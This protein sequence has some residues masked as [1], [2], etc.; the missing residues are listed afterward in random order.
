M[1]R[2]LPDCATVSC[3]D[4]WPSWALSLSAVVSSPR[5]DRDP[6]ILCRFVDSLGYY[7]L[8]LQVGDFGL[9]IYLTQIIFGAV[10]VPARYSSTFMLQK[11][12][13]R[14]SQLGTLVMGGLMCITIIFIPAGTGPGCPLFPP[15]LTHLWPVASLSG[16]RASLGFGYRRGAESGWT[17]QGA[18]PS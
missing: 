14:W 7:G 18:G 12:G 9:D 15:A 10:E 8:S 17:G 3:C 2:C 11:F 13:R 6:W 4:F 1:T 16:G 5:S